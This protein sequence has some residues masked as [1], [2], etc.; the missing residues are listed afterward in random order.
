MDNL[1]QRKQQC[2]QGLAWL[3]VALGDAW[4]ILVVPGRQAKLRHGNSGHT[5][6]TVEVLCRF[7]HRRLLTRPASPGRHATRDLLIF[8]QKIRSFRLRSYMDHQHMELPIAVI[9]CVISAY[10]TIQHTVHYQKLG[11]LWCF[12]GNEGCQQA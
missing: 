7:A 9:F 1:R 5:A 3:Q 4:E 10:A 12:V 6:S 8:F 2:L 11:C